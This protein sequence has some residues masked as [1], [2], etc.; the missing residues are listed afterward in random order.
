MLVEAS[1]VSQAAYGNDGRQH[2]IGFDIFQPSPLLM[3]IYLADGPTFNR[4][5]V[6]FYLH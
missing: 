2:Q 5:A 4:S 6:S 3:A 1:S